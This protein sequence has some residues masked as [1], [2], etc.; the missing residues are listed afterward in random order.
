MVS[1]EARSWIGRSQPPIHMEVTRR[2]IQK[3][4]V[5]TEQRQQKFLNGDEAPPM[6]L[7]GLL[8]PIVPLEGL[9][10]DGI[11]RDGF[12]PDFPLKRIMAGG[13]EMTYHRPLRPGDKL[14]ATKTLADIQEKQGGTGPLIFVSY[15]L[16]VETEDGE[17][18]VEE[19]S[20]RIIR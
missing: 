1:D 4:A 6:F 16:T 9:G 17:V 13:T 14:I 3:Y 5:A 15:D 18:V 7:F 10:P 11:A 19:R 20:T 12:L 2:D 8:R